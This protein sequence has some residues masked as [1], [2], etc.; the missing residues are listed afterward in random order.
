MILG[1]NHFGEVGVK[2]WTVGE[3]TVQAQLVLQQ[4]VQ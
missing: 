3:V 4:L 2:G 1:I